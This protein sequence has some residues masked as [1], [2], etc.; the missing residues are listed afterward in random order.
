MWN[1]PTKFCDY[2]SARLYQGWVAP[3]LPPSSGWDC[4]SVPATISHAADSRLSRTMVESS[5]PSS[6]VGTAA[7]PDTTLNIAVTS[8]LSGATGGPLSVVPRSGLPRSPTLFSYSD[9]IIFNPSRHP[10]PGLTL[11]NQQRRRR[12]FHLNH[13]PAWLDASQNL[14]CGH[15]H[16]RSGP[17]GPKPLQRLSHGAVMHPSRPAPP[18]VSG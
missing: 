6:R 1:E 11:Q 9:R 14:V 5:P 10:F 12:L 17:R 3:P 8:W 7:D 18:F 4:R 16:E 2:G 13:V 15:G